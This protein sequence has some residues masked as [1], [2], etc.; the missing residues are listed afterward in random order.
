[1]SSAE[2]EHGFDGGQPAG[3]GNRVLPMAPQVVEGNVDDETGDIHHPGH[4]VIEGS[5]AEG[6]LVR[7]GGDLTVVELVQGAT[8]ECGGRCTLEHGATAR[9]RCRIRIGGGLAAAYLH[10]VEGQVTGDLRVEGELLNC[11]IAVGG[12][13]SCPAGAVIG[14]RIAATGSVE[15][16]TLGNARE[17]PTM[18]VLGA[19]PMLALRLVR[20]DALLEALEP[21]R[22]RLIDRRRVVRLGAERLTPDEREQLTEIE[23]LLAEIEDRRSAL[24]ARRLDIIRRMRERR[25]VDLSVHDTIH[26]GVTL[27]VGPTELRFDRALDGPVQIMWHEDRSIQ[28]RHAGGPVR[29]VSLVARQSNMAA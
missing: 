1:M 27:L 5:V 10:N 22:Q 3:N 7:C 17:A 6:R 21:R 13:L 28:Y 12:S 16:G 29:P 2:H 14:G 8:L 4:L 9:R 15:V 24:R 23:F 11:S 26:A 25:R 20:I 19:V 18:M